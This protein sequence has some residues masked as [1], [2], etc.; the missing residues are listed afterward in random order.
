MMLV[1]RRVTP[2]SK[3]PVPIYTAGWR[4]N[5]GNVSCLKAPANEETLFP[6]MFLGPANEWETMFPCRTNQETFH[7]KQMFEH[8][9][10][11][12]YNLRYHRIQSTLFPRRANGKHLLWKQMSLKKNQKYFLF[13]RNKKSLRNK[14]FV[15]VQ[16]GKHV[17]K[18]TRWQAEQASNHCP[19]VRAEIQSE[20]PLPHHAASMER[21][22]VLRKNPTPFL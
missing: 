10:F 16:T 22:L 21:N 13:L 18:P 2:S 3:S 7:W 19:S 1:P 11:R 5:V 17:K 8:V 15:R 12:K 4:D 14:C 6:R 20:Q 9:Q